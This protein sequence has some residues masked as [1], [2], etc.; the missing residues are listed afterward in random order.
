[1]VSPEVASP[2]D[3]A[4]SGSGVNRNN[5]LGIL[6]IRRTL[7]WLLLDASGQSGSTVRFP[8]K[9]RAE[10]ST[11]SCPDSSGGLVADK[12]PAQSTPTEDTAEFFGGCED[13]EK[14]RHPDLNGPESRPVNVTDQ[15]SV[16][17]GHIPVPDG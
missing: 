3:S 16:G 6:G 7:Q 5:E 17:G 4:G 2:A 14:R 1:M 15:M 11:V 8:Q 13:K 9:S 12:H 10:P